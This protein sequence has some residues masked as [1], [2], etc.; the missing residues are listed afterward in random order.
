MRFSSKI[1]S[2]KFHHL[3]KQQ[4]SAPTYI[5]VLLVISMICVFSLES[6]GLLNNAKNLDYRLTTPELS[7]K[8][9]NEERK[10]TVND[11]ITEFSFQSNTKATIQ[12][13][14]KENK[15]NTLNSLIMD[16]VNDQMDYEDKNNE[17]NDFIEIKYKQEEGQVSPHLFDI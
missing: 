13:K 11:K 2:Q 8:I 6:L 16:A 1:I 4:W 9:I 17:L 5:S 15:I 3:R 12:T 10:I 7:V 14:L